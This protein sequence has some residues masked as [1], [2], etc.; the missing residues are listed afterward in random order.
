MQSG[1]GVQGPKLWTC[2]WQKPHW[3]HIVFSPG[4]NIFKHSVAT[5]F[6]WGLKVSSDSSGIVL[7]LFPT[8]SATQVCKKEPLNNRL[9]QIGVVARPP[10]LISAGYQIGRT[11]STLDDLDVPQWVQGQNPEAKL[12]RYRTLMYINIQSL[13]IWTYAYTRNDSAG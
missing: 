12:W 9:S 1:A 10:C 6:P 5:A 2:R 4:K 3:I 8:H 13:I 7:V 11:T